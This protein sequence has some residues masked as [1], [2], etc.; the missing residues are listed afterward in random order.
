[1][2]IVFA[3]DNAEELFARRGRVATPKPGRCPGCGHDGLSFAGWWTRHT[4]RGPVDIHRVACARCGATHSLLPDVLLAGRTDDV[5]TIGA[6]VELAARGHGHRPIARML[7]VPATTV[8]DWLRA[9]RRTAPQLTQLLNG[10]KAA[11]GSAVQL[12]RGTPLRVLVGA[13]WLAAGAW[14]LLAGEPVDRWRFANR[15]AAGRLVG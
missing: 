11:C 12:P 14:S 4:R 13:V 9:A 1:M 6:G 5:A 15:H 7:Q 10:V 3:V 8:R 2:L